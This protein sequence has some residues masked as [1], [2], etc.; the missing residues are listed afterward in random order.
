MDA[1]EAARRPRGRRA[2]PGGQA[3]PHPRGPLTAPLTYFFRLSILIYPENIQESHK[4]TFPSPQPTVLVRSH[5]GAF[6][7]DLSEGASIT[8]GF[9]IST[10]ASPMMCELLARWLLLS[11]WISIQ[12]SPTLLWGSIRCNLLLRCVC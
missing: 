9:Y 6:F 4:T 11:F 12:C 10:I 8:E 1:K 2:R 3:R 5:L 7:G